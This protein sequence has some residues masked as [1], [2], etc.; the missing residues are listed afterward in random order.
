MATQT[1]P[2]P[3][4]ASAGTP[5]RLQAGDRLTRIEFERRYNAMPD[6]KKAELIEGVVYMPSPVSTVNH[7]EPHFEL[8]TWLGIYC[9]QTPGVF[10]ADNA[11]NRLDVD[12]EPQ[13][14]AH[15]RIERG[16][17]SRVVDG[18]LEGPAELVAEISASSA[19]YDLHDKLNAYRRN[20]VKEYIVWRV[21][22]G[23][24][25]WFVLREG[26]YAPLPLSPDGSYRS[27]VFP[28]LWLD[29]AAMISRNLPRVFEVLQA[30][31]ASAEHVEFVRKMQG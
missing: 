28:G 24:I 6:V 2:N 12:N 20:G 5:P 1:I 18:F 30:G 8:I 31:L 27:E 13:P 16:G 3:K 10:G 4:P 23:A 29:P 14:D 25:D 15:L 17:S 22:D 26:R 19:S 21:L 11:T 7:G 9:L